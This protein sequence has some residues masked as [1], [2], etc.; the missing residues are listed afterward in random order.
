MATYSYTHTKPLPVF[1]FTFSYL[2]LQSYLSILLTQTSSW[3]TEVALVIA[4][5][6]QR[7]KLVLLKNKTMSRTS[8]TFII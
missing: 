4:S 3:P 7:S 8:G 5:Q 2:V 1:G 6:Q